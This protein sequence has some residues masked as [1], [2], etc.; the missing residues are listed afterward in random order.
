[1]T[2]NGVVYNYA[3]VTL[4]DGQYFTFAVNLPTPGGVS[5]PAVW[6][7]PN[8]VTN[9][10]W[11]DASVNGMDL[12]NQS[13]TGDTMVMAGNQAHN[14]HSWTTGYSSNN[15][16]NYIDSSAASTNLEDN[17]VFGNYNSDGL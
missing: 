15:Y 5:L 13:T 4:A 10:G 2:V 16:Y 9:S 6:Y 1:Q 7:K 11:A 8:G 3:D 17:P 14:F 12:T